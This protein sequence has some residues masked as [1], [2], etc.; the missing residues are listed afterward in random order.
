MAGID[1]NRT[2]DGVVLPKEVSSEIWANVQE[3]SAVMALARQISL[4]GPG[5]TIPVITGDAEADWVGETELKPV[6]RATLGSKDITPYKLA[7]IEP[8]SN[9][10][11]RDLPGLYAELARR[12]PNAL[13]KKFDE[14]VFGTT[15]PGSNFAT[16]GAATAVPIA[17]HASN[18]KLSTYAGLANAY[19]AVANAGG[20]LDGWAL[21]SQAKGLLIKQT[22]STGRPLLFDSI[23][24][25][26]SVPQLLGERV[27]YTRG[28]YASGT[29]GDPNTIGFAGDWSSAVWGTVEGIKVDIDN[30]A[31]LQDGTVEAPVTGGEGGTVSVPNFINLWQRNMFAVLVEVEVG[32]QVRDVSR[33]VRLTDATVAA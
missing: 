16:L 30:K 7:V 14:T 29:S 32:F 20:Q 2:T 18:D 21:S 10:F 19:N 3:A 6:S 17:P 12:L 8:F 4:P 11:R 9:E 31:T 1:I 24:A 13:A 33:F 28:V 25:G 22:D 26:T 27:H 15:A 23:Q 5:V